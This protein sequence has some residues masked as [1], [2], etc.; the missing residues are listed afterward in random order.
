MK[1]IIIVIFG[2]LL[3]SC[4]N[5]EQYEK[6]TGEWNCSKWIVESTGKDRCNN[7][8]Y[9]NFKSD[10]TYVSKIGGL[11]EVGVYRIT[12]GLLYS[13][14]E[15]KMEISVEINT[16]HKD[17]LQFIMSRSGEKETLTLLRKK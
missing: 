9:F 1:K 7:N 12:N 11:E 8:V 17:T 10:K 6:I 15:G 4:D 5:S 16:L 3:I 2:L 13:T 14:P